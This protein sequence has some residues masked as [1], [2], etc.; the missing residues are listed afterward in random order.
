MQKR[1]QSAE[2]AWGGDLSLNA[3]VIGIH[4]PGDIALYARI[5]GL[6]GP[7]IIRVDHFATMVLPEIDAPV[8]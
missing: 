1:M 7:S 8:R 2:V 6:D 3:K 4:Q 5:Q